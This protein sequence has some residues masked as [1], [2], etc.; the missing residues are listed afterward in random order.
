MKP[1]LLVEDDESV[2]EVAT[3]VFTDAGY[4]TKSFDRAADAILWMQS[5]VPLCV[6][7]DLMLP[8]MEGL[9][10]LKTFKEMRP[11]VEVIVYTAFTTDYNRGKIREIAKRLGACDFIEKP[12]DINRLVDAIAECVGDDG[13]Q[14]G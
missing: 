2:R 9:V 13:C 6:V 11:E 5:N 12:F 10:V 7:L 8:D 1:I 14:P 4:E 3:D